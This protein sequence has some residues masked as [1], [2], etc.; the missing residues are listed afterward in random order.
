MALTSRDRH[1]SI[2]APPRGATESCTQSITQGDYFNSRPSARGDALC[3]HQR[4]RAKHFNSRPSARGDLLQ[5][6]HPRSP[7]RFQ[8][9][10]LREGRQVPTEPLPVF[11]LFQFTPLREGR[12]YVTR[13]ELNTLTNFNSRPSARGDE[14][15]RKAET[16]ISISIHA[17]PRGATFDAQATYAESIFQFTPLR[18][19]RLA[20]WLNAAFY[21]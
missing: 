21:P 10:P 8:F 17:P 14:A 20:R 9:T 11:R 15:K 12:Q 5:P 7:H 18:E 1:I 16:A 19:G 6:H 4:Q 2:H 3:V 13:D